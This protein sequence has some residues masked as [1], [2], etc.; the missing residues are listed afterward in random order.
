MIVL[1]V[2]IGIAQP[3]G[4]ASARDL[5]NDLVAAAS[6]NKRAKASLKD[7]ALAEYLIQAA[8]RSALRLPEK[9]R[10]KAFLI[11]VGIGLDRSALMRKN[12]LLGGMWRVI[13]NNAQRDE[14][15][16][17]IDIPTLFG[18]HDL[19]QHFAVSAMLTTLR[20][21]K[22][23]EAIG[24]AKEYLD[25]QPGG[26]GF[27]FADLRADFGGVRFAEAVLRDSRLLEKLSK[28]VRLADHALPPKGLAEG[29][30]ADEF[31]KRYGSLSDHRFRAAC[32][33]LKQRLGKL[34]GFGR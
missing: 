21:A 8:A 27:S 13:E 18:R 10:S 11:A 24:I 14:R 22:T 34:P 20:G 32:D 28:G 33:E 16:K 29:L 7:D 2:L 5:L 19:L 12:P 17:V 15:L 3:D 30:T 4:I 25:A 9:E 23:A 31:A 1:V 26:S 6:D